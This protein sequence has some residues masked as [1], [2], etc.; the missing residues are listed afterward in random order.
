[1]VGKEVVGK[2]LRLAG[3]REEVTPPSRDSMKLAT[4][5]EVEE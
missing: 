2:F 5:G 3:F 1:V 4:K